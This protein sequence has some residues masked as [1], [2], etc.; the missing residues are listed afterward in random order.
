MCFVNI[1]ALYQH[2][3]PMQYVHKMSQLLGFLHVY[4]GIQN[5]TGTS[6]SLRLINPYKEKLMAS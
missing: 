6:A 1:T 5:S 3:I 4:E 2:K